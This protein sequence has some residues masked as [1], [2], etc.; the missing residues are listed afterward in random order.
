MQLRGHLH[1]PHAPPRYRRHQPSM[2]RATAC[3]ST[4]ARSHPMPADA[5][6]L[7]AHAPHEAASEPRPAA[8]ALATVSQLTY[9]H[10][11]PHVP[12]APSSRT[13]AHTGASCAARSR[14]IRRTSPTVTCACSDGTRA[15]RQ[16]TTQ[17]PCDH[18]HTPRRRTPPTPSRQ[19][20]AQAPGSAPS[21]VGGP[22]PR[23]SHVHRAIPHPR[24]E[25]VPKRAPT[26][27]DRR[28][29]RAR[30]RV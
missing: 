24:R 13:P 26:P 2:R 6:V 16:H 15:P 27:D 20:G 18:P 30:P 25:R 19:T 11:P 23:T 22:V 14:R 1:R 9:S 21:K 10:V 8:S 12:Y 4:A 7:P 5:G 29:H 28:V 17:P 3:P